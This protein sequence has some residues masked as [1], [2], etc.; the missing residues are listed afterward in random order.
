MSRFVYAVLL[1]CAAAT[2]HADVLINAGGG[3]ISP[4]VADR[5]FSGGNAWQFGS[6]SIPGVYRTERWSET[7]FSYAIPVTAGQVEV[8]LK[9]RESCVPC[10]TRS[11]NVRAEGVTVLSNFQVAANAT[12]DQTFT[13]AS[14]STLNLQ[15]TTVLNEAWVNAIEV[16][17]ISGSPQP[18][19]TLSLTADPTSVSSGGSTSLS[20]TS[21]NAT[22][23]AASDGWSGN[24]ATSGSQSVG[25][26]NANTTF[27]LSCTGTGG[28]VTR[29]VAVTVAATPP[30]PTVSLTASPSSVLRGEGSSLTWSSTNANSCTA[31]GAWSGTK[32]TSGNEQTGALTQTSTFTLTCS[33]TGGSA[34]QS[35]TVTVTAPPVPTVTLTASPTSV[36]QGS[37]SN[38]SWSSTN[39]DTCSASGAWSGLKGPS[40]NQSTGALSQTSTFSLSCSGPGGSAS[41]S[42]T[43][44][45]T[46]PAPT[47]TLSASPTVVP[48][49]GSTT[50]TWSGAN[51][52]ECTASDGWSGSR[53][54][55]GSEV[56]SGLTQD[57]TY[58][59]SCSGSGGTI[60]RSAAVSIADTAGTALLRV[61]GT[62]PRYF[63]DATGKIVI[64]AGSHTW[65]NFQDNGG[66]NPPPT[67]NYNG[68]LDFLSGLGHNFF[69]LWTWEQ[70]RWTLET[71][72]NNYW[73]NPQ[74]PYVRT[75]PGNAL[76]GRLKFDLTQFNQ[77]YFDRMRAR[78]QAAG[79][80]GMYVAV[81]LFNGWSVVSNK[82]SWQANNP[83][84]GHPFHASNNINGV[85]GDPGNNSSGEEVHELLVPSVTAAQDAYVRKVIDTL[86]DLDNVLYEIS[87]ESHSRSEQWQ[88]HMIDLIKAYE[89]TKPKQHPVGMTVEYP[90]GSNNELYAS[91]ADYVS[92]N[93][94]PSNPPT[95]TGSK[96]VIS[97]SDHLCG[98]CGDR[99]WVWRSFTRGQNPAFMDGYD[100]AGYGVGGSGFSMNN[101]TWVSLRRNL[102]YIIDVSEMFDLHP[103][104]PRGTSTASTGYALGDPASGQFIVY[105]PN[106]G[107][108]TVN[109]AG[110]SGTLTVRWL[111]PST[112]QITNGTAVTGGATRSFSTPFS[113]DSVLL[114]K[115]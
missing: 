69:R 32:T 3:A 52:T 72:D 111:S 34:S 82:S 59:L 97:D 76:D 87:N 57:T 23:C 93:G 100:G 65:S 86:N 25:P 70:T 44:T 61:S 17:Q 42:R 74:T 80:R 51:V 90:N 71:S 13:I 49:D 92:P 26:L 46:A 77:A 24:K 109:L 36:V 11:F 48:A 113:G 18:P 29:S 7:G 16:K 14:D 55:S 110:V 67:F 41:Q 4:Y 40:G 88:Y 58:T 112:G 75:G 28:A 107:S 50:L 15:F 10:Y 35:R 115:R 96:V 37:A 114:L 103:M 53:S 98:I 22:S 62:N 99:R 1:T 101:P 91:N 19:P 79:D 39:A 60:E 5:N 81:V 21:T 84:R 105:S 83:W 95:N 63:E 73:F 106:G 56:I 2:A 9:F 64:L 78:V 20:W 47:L 85:N 8:T 102:G 66:S 104:T 30:Q 6:S 54:A 27:T 31:S 108:F 68:Y 33:G 94:D 89:A 45:V 38:L 43:V 12:N